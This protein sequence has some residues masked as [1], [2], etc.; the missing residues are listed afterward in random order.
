M[1]VSFGYG[2]I[3]VFPLGPLGSEKRGLVGFILGINIVSRELCKDILRE[4]NCIEPVLNIR[5]LF[6]VE[7]FISEVTD[8]LLELRCCVF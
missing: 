5:W 6:F 2:S 8:G 7:I 1:G 3:E 4:G